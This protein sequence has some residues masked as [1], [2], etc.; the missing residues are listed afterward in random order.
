LISAD[1]AYARDRSSLGQILSNTLDKYGVNISE[2]ASGTIQQKPH[3]PGLT[4][5]QPPAPPKPLTDAPPPI[6]Q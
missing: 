1:A 6:P 4:A 2:A 5:P 3:I